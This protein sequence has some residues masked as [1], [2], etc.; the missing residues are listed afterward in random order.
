M[1]MAAAGTALI[2]YMIKPVLD[3]IFIEKNEHLLYL[4]PFGLVGV[5][6]LKSLGGYLQAYY[7]AYIGQDIVRRLRDQMV[8]NVLSFEM[9]FFHRMR[10]GELISRSVNDIERVRNVVSSMI[11]MMIRE[12]LT[13]IFLIIYIIYL[14]PKMALITLVF[15]PLAAKPLSMLAK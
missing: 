14:N 5:Y 8:K 15:L 13:I 10:S 9:D 4:L 12:V 1:I 11:P 7:S 6:A 2:A 3:K